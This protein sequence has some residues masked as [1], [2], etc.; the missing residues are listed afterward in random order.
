[1]IPRHTFNVKR[2]LPGTYNKG[3]YVE[4]S[5]AL[6]SISASKQPPTGKE[7]LLMPEGRRESETY[8]L[9]TDVKLN[10]A[11]QGGANADR[12][13]I[14]GEDFEVLKCE[15]WQNDIINHY[16]ATVQRRIPG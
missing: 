7:M 3:R 15:T 9:Y 10:P 16:R 4:G 1:M 12:V 5:E 11:I 13:V 6:F 2:Y 14:D 8:I